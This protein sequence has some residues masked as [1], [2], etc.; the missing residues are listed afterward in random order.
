MADILTNEIISCHCNDMALSNVTKP[1]EKFGHTQRYRSLA[2]AGI[3]GK[4]HVQTWLPTNEVQ[5]RTR[6]IHEQQG[7]YLPYARLDWLES[8][9]LSV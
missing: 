6:S 2:G 8:D 9:Q 5:L 4:A 7:S 1:S 3:T